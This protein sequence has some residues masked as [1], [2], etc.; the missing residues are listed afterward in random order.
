MDL[1]SLEKIKYKWLQMENNSVSCECIIT[2]RNVPV[3]VCV[4]SG[5]G[6]CV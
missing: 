3:S 2:G 1:F 4:M 5:M 6:V